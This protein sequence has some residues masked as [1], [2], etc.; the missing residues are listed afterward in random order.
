[1]EQGIFFNPVPQQSVKAQM[2]QRLLSLQCFFNG[3]KLEFY[4]ERRTFGISLG[5]ELLRGKE[6]S[7]RQ[8]LYLRHMKTYT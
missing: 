5:F 7:G 8:T 1:M 6:L 2:L 3:L 4:Q